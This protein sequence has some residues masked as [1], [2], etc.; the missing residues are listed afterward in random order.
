[1]QHRRLDAPE[2]SPDT[3]SPEQD[4]LS[5]WQVPPSSRHAES[6][7]VKIKTESMSIFN[8]LTVYV[9]YG[10]RLLFSPSTFV[11]LQI[12]EEDMT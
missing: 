1:M 8:Y 6:S 10:Y 11:H 3:Y 5:S 9:I 12:G 4:K 7:P 2:H